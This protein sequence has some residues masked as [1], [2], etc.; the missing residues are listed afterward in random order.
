MSGAPTARSSASTRRRRAWRARPIPPRCWRRARTRP[1]LQIYFQGER[2]MAKNRAQA[3]QDFIGQMVRRIYNL[4]AR[5]AT[6]SRPENIAISI[7]TVVVG[8]I[9]D[10]A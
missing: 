7:L 5:R 4:R 8:Q 9:D 1:K 2:G 3:E 6:A 10:A